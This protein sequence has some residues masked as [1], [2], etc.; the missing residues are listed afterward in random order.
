MT[1]QEARLLV[2]DDSAHTRQAF[3]TAL[4]RLGVH[5]VDEAADGESALSRLAQARYD[6]VISDWYMP[7]MSGLDLVRRIR[8]SLELR[9]LPVLITLGTVTRARVLEAAEAGVSGFLSRP[10]V[11]QSLEERLR[12]FIGPRALHP[13]AVRVH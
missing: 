11:T 12:I 2:V 6:V 1:R 7:R 8:S 13:E 9:N 4:R 10:I 5:H 3:I